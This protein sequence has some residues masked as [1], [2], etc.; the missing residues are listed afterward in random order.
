MAWEIQGNIRGPQGVQGPEGPQGVAGPAGPAG[1]NWR[2]AWLN[3]NAYAEDDAVSWGGSTYFATA[4]HAA[5]ANEPPTGVVGD[6]G[7]D[8]AAVNA[9][10]ALLSMQGAQ[11]AQGAQGVQ[12]PQGDPGPQGNVGP[13][14]PA[15]DVG[16]QGPEGDA[17]PQGPQGV[18]GT[19][20]YTGNGA[21]G[22]I[23]GSAVGDKYMDLQT[24]DV[25]TLA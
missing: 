21:P 17:G 10:W 12:G 3:A 7:A 1:L 23:A 20:W 25:Y 15:G 2:G 6:P 4:A 16:P 18:R 11:G 9:G 24:G 8:D 14:G 19:N 13:Q 5:G 22:V